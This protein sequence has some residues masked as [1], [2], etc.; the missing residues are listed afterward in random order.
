[1]EQIYVVGNSRSGTTLLSRILGKHSQVFSFKELHFFEEI[2]LPTK[3]LPLLANDQSLGLL[4]KLI[5]TQKDGYYR[6]QDSA[7]YRKEA[8][9][10]LMELN[11]KAT[12]PALFELFLTHETRLHD[13]QIA[14]LQTPR[15]L[16]Y[17]EYI[18]DFYPDARVINIIRD[19]RDVVLSQKNKWRRVFSDEPPPLRETIRRWAN[20]HPITISLLWNSAMR[21]IEPYQNHPRVLTIYF[22]DLV[23]N[24]NKQIN[25]ICDFLGIEMEQDLLDIDQ[26]GSSF[27]KYDPTARGMNKNTV[28]R[29]RSQRSID[30]WITQIVS[31]KHLQ[32]QGYELASIPLN[33]LALL[34]SFAAFPIKTGLA[35][36]LNIHRFENIWFSI[37]QRLFN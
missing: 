16:Y 14:C 32:T 7:K 37:K 35:F 23:M 4:G 8:A 15:N 10:I 6:T 20:Y 27:G 2:W 31:R 36:L 22:E 1:M 34:A 26:R 3:S 19:G 5:T 21:A 17:L 11:D 29:W 28:E 12:P 18:L 33:P 9:K 13:K 24:P 30:I 25:M